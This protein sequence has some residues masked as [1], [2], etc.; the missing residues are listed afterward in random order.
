[1]KNYTYAVIMTP[2]NKLVRMT[3]IGKKHNRMLKIS[4]LCGREY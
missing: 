1:M 2:E 4:F 3:M